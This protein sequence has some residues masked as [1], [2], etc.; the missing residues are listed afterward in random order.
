MIIKT[1]YRTR[2]GPRRVKNHVQ[3]EEVIINENM[4]SPKSEKI[5]IAFK[6]NSTSGLVE[7]RPDEIERLISTVKGKTRLIKS[8]KIIKN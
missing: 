4:T 3:I 5:E 8:I 1:K 7:F 2:D 6:N